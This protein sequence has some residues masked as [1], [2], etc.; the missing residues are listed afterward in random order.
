MTKRTSTLFALGYCFLTS[1]SWGGDFDKMR[2]DRVGWAR[3]QTPSEYWIRHTRGDPVLARFLRDNTSLNV[4]PT[5]YVADVEKLNELCKFPMLFSQGIGM[6]TNTTAKANLGEYIRRGGFL[7]I[8]SCINRGITPDP[9][10]FLDAQ[11]RV[12]A[13][14]LPEARVVE[15]PSGHDIYH[16][17]FTIPDGVPP[18]MFDSDIYD[19]RWA[20]HGLYGIMIGSRMVG[21]ISLSGLQ[22][23]W[24]KMT[25]RPGL[26]EACMRMVTNIYVYAMLQAN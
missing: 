2:S 10:R 8:D 17:Y 25:N 6:I 16:C 14:I 1:L 23:G 13:E 4:D 21:L 12:L 5:W 7:L 15:L 19:A 11:V 24:D 22:C 18:H 26:P 9:D 20:R 3:L